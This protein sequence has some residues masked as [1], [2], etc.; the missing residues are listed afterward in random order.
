LITIG[1][2]AGL[3]VILVAA[4]ALIAFQVRIGKKGF[5]GFRRIPAFD[6]LKK[7]IGLAVENGT[8]IHVTLGKSSLTQSS[9]PSALVGLTTLERIGHSSSISDRPPVS[10]SGD[11]SVAILS[12]DTLRTVYR[13]VNAPELF[14]ASRGQLSGVTPLSYIAGAIPIVADEDVSANVMIGNFGPEIALLSE[15]AYN[16]SAF[17]LAASDNLAAQA[18]LF[19]SADDPI[20]GE[21][22]FAAPTYLDAGKAHASSLKVQDLLRWLIILGLFT[23]AVLKLAGVL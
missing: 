1:Q 5:P 17:S 12:Q 7:A 4:G 16:Q 22:L 2:V 13:S 10:T 3:A 18:A 6:H 19:I 11:P 23:G 15:A 14:D 8:R 9:I 20:I 21:E